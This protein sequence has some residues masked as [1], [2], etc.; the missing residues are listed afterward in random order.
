MP[1][2][3]AVHDVDEGAPAGS[4]AGHA[5]ALVHAVMRAASEH[6]PLLLTPDGIWLTLAQG[7]ARH[8]GEQPTGPFI[9]NFSTTTALERIACEI[10]LQG[11]G[12]QEGPF[13]AR[14]DQGIP[15]ITVDG[16]TRDWADIQARLRALEECGLRWWTKEVIPVVAHFEEAAAGSPDRAFFAGVTH[17]LTRLFPDRV[18]SSLARGMRVVEAGQQP[19]AVLGG[20]VG[21]KLGDDG[22]LAP[23]AGWMISAAS[24]APRS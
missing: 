8:L 9:S 12:A 1:V 4:G 22:H 17:W 11:G 21:V 18:P 7:F 15:R 14:P 20:F 10:V 23:E 24:S 5:H 3:F 13:D 2:T 6:R 16:T 19:V